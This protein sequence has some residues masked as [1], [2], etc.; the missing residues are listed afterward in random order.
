M[1]K[2]YIAYGSNLSV[3]Q[4]KLRC[5]TAKAV[6]ITGLKDWQLVFRTHATIERKAGAEVPAA[7]WE[8]TDED[9]RNLDLYEGC[10][11]YY[12]K[13]TLNVTMK[14]FATRR[15]RKINAMVYIMNNIRPV[16]PPM[17]GYYEVI[18]E[19]YEYFGLNRRIL[20]RALDDSI[21]LYTLENNII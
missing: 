14:E 2:Y 3:E 17:R 11:A 20:R 13:A 15:K 10:P 8:I 18:E 7:V 4:M 9:E 5:P 21:Y 1:S 16:T 6:G 19:G 12:H